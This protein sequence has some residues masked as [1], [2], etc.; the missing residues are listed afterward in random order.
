M[1]VALTRKHVTV[2]FEKFELEWANRWTARYRG[3]T[4]YETESKYAALVE[5]YWKELSDLPLGAVRLGFSQAQALDWPPRP[6]EL[7][8]FAKAQNP[9]QFLPELAYLDKQ[10]MAT[11]DQV[12]RHMKN[13]RKIFKR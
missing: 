7:R 9:G 6:R 10:D 3:D 1:D 13:I 5:A 8:G 11:P 12:S 2:M 4:P